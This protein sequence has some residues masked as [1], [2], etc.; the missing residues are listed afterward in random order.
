VFYGKYQWW[1]GEACA[2]SH[3]VAQRRYY[4]GLSLLFMVFYDQ[5]QWW[6]G[7]ACSSGNGVAKKRCYG[8]SVLL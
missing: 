2:S 8:C 5:N 1:G 3:S 4:M 7:E 6:D